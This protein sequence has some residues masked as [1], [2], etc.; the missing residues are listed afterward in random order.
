MSN[1]NDQDWTPVVL[2]PKPQTGSAKQKLNQ[3][4]RQGLEI[5]TVRK[6]FSGGN[7]QTKP[8][9]LVR[10]NAEDDEI[11]VIPKVSHSVS[12]QIVSARVAKGWTRKELA[13]KLNVKEVVIAE[14][15]TGTATVDHKLLQRMRT[16]LGAPLK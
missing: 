1:P 2:K 8:N 13:Q 11:G 12:Q 16:L 3:A 7:K 5:E 4:Q 6:P 10:V 9:P 14:Y 15:E